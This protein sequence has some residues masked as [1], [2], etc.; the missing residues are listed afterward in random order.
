VVNDGKADVI[1]LELLA[2][3]IARFAS[4]LSA[5]GA[6]SGLQVH[7]S[8][9]KF[10]RIGTFAY[11]PGTRKTLSAG[12]KNPGGVDDLV[13]VYFDRPCELRGA[14]KDRAGR[15]VEIEA[16]I[17]V[18]GF[19][20]LLVSA[21]PA[22][23]R[24]V[25]LAPPI[26]GVVLLVERASPA[27]RVY[28]N[29]VYRWSITY[30]SSWTVDSGNLGFVKISSSVDQALCGIHSREVPFRTVDE[31]TDALERAT[32]RV[33]LARRQISL[34][35]DVIGND[36]LTRILGGGKSRRIYTLSDG[37]GFAIDCETYD[38]DW[39]R[40]EPFY[41]RIIRSFTLGK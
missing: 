9:T 2:S 26:S 30:P 25:A 11:E 28:A 4:A 40:L 10:A 34:P 24:R 22:G 13:L 37:R 35:N 19:H 6:T 32:D 17:R 7:P 3:E 31:Y 12:F 36:V 29:A 27:E 16:T 39:D 41:D 23:A 14:S 20:W 33:V 38:K 1:E 8:D 15:T 18:P 21:A 5:E